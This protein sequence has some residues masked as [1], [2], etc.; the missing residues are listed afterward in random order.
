[1]T[2][3]ENVNVFSLPVFLKVIFVFINISHPQIPADLLEMASEMGIDVD[4]V[5]GAEEVPQTCSIEVAASSTQ[6]IEFMSATEWNVLPST[7]SVLE[8]SSAVPIPSAAT[9]VHSRKRRRSSPSPASKLLEKAVTS[10][11]NYQ[12]SK[13]TPAPKPEHS[14]F[15]EM[16]RKE[17]ASCTKPN[18]LLA[19]R[20][21]S[22]VLFLAN[23]DLINV[24]TCIQ[25]NNP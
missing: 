23:Y 20:L 16:V 17:L 3:K 21:I 7:N 22:E 12:S 13:A 15:C 25:K 1:M 10:L 9:P 6:P 8:E 11:E 18:V 14:E 19:K 4:D 2:Y 24:N 5:G